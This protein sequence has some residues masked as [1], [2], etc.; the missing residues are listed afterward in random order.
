MSLLS[1]AAEHGLVMCN[2]SL[3]GDPEGE[4][5]LVNAANGGCSVVDLAL[6]SITLLPHL[7]SFKVLNWTHSDHFPITLTLH[8]SLQKPDTVARPLQAKLSVPINSQHRHAFYKDLESAIE[9]IPI[10]DVN[11]A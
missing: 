3:P 9:T 2:G 1:A 8:H 6:T 5:T 11:R 10:N 4:F 7:E